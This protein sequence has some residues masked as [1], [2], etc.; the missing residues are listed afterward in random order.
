RK[1]TA[2]TTSAA[3]TAPSALRASRRSVGSIVA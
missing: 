3:S 1:M 2:I